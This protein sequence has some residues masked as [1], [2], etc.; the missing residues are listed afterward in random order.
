M[1]ALLHVAAKA[2]CADDLL[3]RSPVA[4]G[5]GGVT[6][7]SGA[8]DV[9]L[10]S[11]VALGLGGVTPASGAAEYLAEAGSGLG[12]R[13]EEAGHVEVL[14]R[15]APLDLQRLDP[16][17]ETFHHR[18]VEMLAGGQGP[19]DDGAAHPPRRVVVLDA[20]ETVAELG[21]ASG[22]GFGLFLLE[23]HGPGGDA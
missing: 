12:A 20:Q 14:A 22:L 10:R 17:V 19:V 4:L 9:F 21:L 2:H 18:G 15:V 5:L 13:L 1:C 7:A 6:P 16:V 3:L 23:G 8:D 11:P